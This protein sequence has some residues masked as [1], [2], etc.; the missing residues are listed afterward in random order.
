VQPE[1]EQDPR[2]RTRL[3]NNISKIKDFG[4]DIIRYDPKKRGFLAQVTHP[5][6]VE[7]VPI[8]YAEALR[9][10]HWKRA[11]QDEYEALIRNGTWQ[12][13]PPPPSG[14]VV[15]CKWI[16]KV[17][18]HADGSLE[19]YKARLVAKGFHQ[20]HGLD[21][22]ETFSPVIK[23]TTVCLVL[24][25]AVSNGWCIRQADV[26]N[27]FLNG[28]LQETVFMTQPPGFVTSTQPQHVCRL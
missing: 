14:N 11:M 17:K 16:F 19:R 10:P 26:K 1:P 21:Y 24:S 9:S 22:D 20:R 15:D 4:H 12:L 3:C 8:S 28:A 13:T 5:D 2:P 6:N 23:P 27:A 7:S 25:I 18:R